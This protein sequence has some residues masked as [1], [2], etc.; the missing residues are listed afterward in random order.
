MKVVTFSLGDSVGVLFSLL[1]LLTSDMDSVVKGK[2][3]EYATLYFEFIAFYKCLSEV[4]IIFFC[5]SLSAG[6]PDDGK[7]WPPFFRIIHHD[8]TNEIP[9]PNIFPCNHLCFTWN[10]TLI[11]AVVQD[12]LSGNSTYTK[13]GFTVH[14]C[15]SLF[16]GQWS[17]C[18]ALS[19]FLLS[20]GCHFS[21][22][23]LVDP[24]RLFTEQDSKNKGEY[25]IG[26]QRRGDEGNRRCYNI[27]IERTKEED[28]KL[29]WDEHEQG[30]TQLLDF[31]LR[32]KSANLGI[33][34]SFFFFWLIG[35]LF[36]QSTIYCMNGSSS[37]N[38]LTANSNPLNG[39][40]AAM[41]LMLK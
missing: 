35:N 10:T 37:L 15:S 40:A 25:D 5:S 28:G 38:F 18:F 17:D 31:D 32:K 12:P 26:I 13:C 30:D 1:L 24:P 27:E 8:I 34:F 33:W 23:F 6:V 9:V 20:T 3:Y 19:V 7:D 36:I 2:G 16:I 14:P 11:C 22:A 41:W 4:V 39:V 21:W 29:E